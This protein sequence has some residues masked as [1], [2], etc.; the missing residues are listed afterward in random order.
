MNMSVKRLIPWTDFSF[1]VLIFWLNCIETLELYATTLHGSYSTSYTM[2]V[3]LS[4]KFSKE[5]PFRL[6][7]NLSLYLSHEKLRQ[8]PQWI[9]LFSVVASETRERDTQD[10]CLIMPASQRPE[11]V[12]RLW[13]N[14]NN[15]DK[16]RNWRR[17]IEVSDIIT[18]Y[19]VAASRG[20]SVK[21]GSFSINQQ[22]F[23]NEINSKFLMNSPHRISTILQ[24]GTNG[25]LSPKAHRDTARN[26]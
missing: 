4:W 21:S 15:E 3:K 9:V 2:M 19:T 14:M 26:L 12:V 11:H 24:G 10:R 22:C 5:K 17:I 6:N 23:I 25:L 18:G 20:F 1:R 8:Q 7:H 16:L 13:Y